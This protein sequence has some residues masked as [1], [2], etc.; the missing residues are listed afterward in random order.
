[1]R[2]QPFGFGQP[3]GTGSDRLLLTNDRELQ[4]REA[5]ST[6]RTQEMLIVFRVLECGQ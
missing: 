1:M 3:A 4:V 2:G 6:Q 5:G